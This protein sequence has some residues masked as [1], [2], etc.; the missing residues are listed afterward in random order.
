M[1]ILT[2]VATCYLMGDIEILSLFVLIGLFDA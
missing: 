2:E 1:G